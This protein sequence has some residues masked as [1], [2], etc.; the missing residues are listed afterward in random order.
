MQCDIGQIAVQQC[1][2]HSAEEC[3]SWAKEQGDEE[4]CPRYSVV[5]SGV[6]FV[7]NLRK[8]L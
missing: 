1:S 6:V 3:E 2:K 5:S 4:A 7:I 8:K